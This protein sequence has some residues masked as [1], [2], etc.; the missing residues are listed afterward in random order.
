M[1]AAAHNDP[2]E[3]EIGFTPSVIHSSSNPV[4]APGPGP[5]PGSNHGNNNASTPVGGGGHRQPFH[6]A[7][8]ATSWAGAGTGATYTSPPKTS[9]AVFKPKA[10]PS[11]GSY[12][13]LS[14]SNDKRA[15]RETFTG[16][17]TTTATGVKSWEPPARKRPAPAAGPR[18]HNPSFANRRPVRP[19]EN[20]VKSPPPPNKPEWRGAQ[21]G[22]GGDR[23]GHVPKPWEKPRFE[24]AN[25]K[26]KPEW[27]RS[28]SVNDIPGPPSGGPGGSYYGPKKGHDEAPTNDYYGGASLNKDI[29]FNPP[30]PRFHPPPGT[31]RHALA[32]DDG[33]VKREDDSA[34]DQHQRQASPTKVRM[35]GSL[36]TGR[37]N[38]D[39]IS[40]PLASP[41]RYNSET[42]W[43]QQD[44]PFLK[45]RPSFA[46]PS[47]DYNEIEQG[48]IDSGVVEMEGD[49]S[50]GR[51][52]THGENA[53]SGVHSLVSAK[54][55][56]LSSDME[57]EPT[58]LAAPERKPIPVILTCASLQDKDAAKKAM[59]TIRI[60]SELMD[61]GVTHHS[62]SADC[63][64]LPNAGDVTKAL[65]ELQKQIKQGQQQSKLVK[66]KMK[67]AIRE[68]MAK[69]K[70]EEELREK[71][72]AN[73]VLKKADEEAKGNSMLLT[74]K[75]EENKVK[76]ERRIA[77]EQL[78]DEISKAQSSI[79]ELDEKIIENVKASIM[80]KYETIIGD[81]QKVSQ[82]ARAG[83]SAV[84]MAASELE[85]QLKDVEHDLDEGVSV[86]ALKRDFAAQ[87]EANSIKAIV[88]SEVSDELK[89]VLDTGV[90]EPD[91]LNNL[92]LS[93]MREN[94]QR[95]AQA[96]FESVTMVVPEAVNDMHESISPPGLV[97]ELP[98]E[99]EVSFKRYVAHW[100]KMTQFVTGPADALYSEPSLAPLYEKTWKQHKEIGPLVKEH[101]RSKK[102]KL[103]H[104]WTELAEEYAVREQLYEKDSKRDSAS[105]HSTAFGGSF[106]ICGQRR[107]GGAVDNTSNSVSA[108][109][110]GNSRSTNNPYRRPRRSAGLQV[111]GGDIVRSDYEQEQIILQLT[112]QENMERRIKLG[113]SDLPRQ[114]CRLEKVNIP[115]R[116]EMLCLRSIILTLFLSIQE[117]S[118]SF[119]DTMSSRR[120][121]DL[122]GDE[123]K[124]SLIN[125]WSDMEKCIFF[126]RFLQHPK[127]FRKIA[128]F[129][130][131]KNTHD[132][133]AFYYSSKQSVPYKAALKEHLMRKKKRGDNVSWEATIQAAISLGATVTAGI[134][135]EKPLLFHLPEN[136]QTYNTRMLH[137]ITLDLF[138]PS[139]SEITYEEPTEP[140][141]RKK[142]AALAT[143]FTL[144]QS[145]RKY[146]RGDSAMAGRRPS[147]SDAES[148]SSAKIS[149]SSSML[150]VPDVAT[151]T[152]QKQENSGRRGSNKW[153]ENEKTVFYDSLEKFGKKWT[154]ISEAIG[155]KTST[156]ARN[157]YYDQKRQNGGNKGSDKEKKEKESK[158]VKS[159]KVK[160]PSVHPSQDIPFTPEQ[161]SMH[162]AQ[163]NK[164]GG[165]PT[166]V[167]EE[168]N[169][170]GEGISGMDQGHT[171][172]LSSQGAWES[173]Q[174][175][176]A[177]EQHRR[178]QQQQQE[179][180]RMLEHQFA[181][182]QLLDQQRQIQHQQHQQHQHFLGM[183]NQQQN[184]MGG[185]PHWLA[186]QALQRQV[187]SGNPLRDFVDRGSMQSNAHQQFNMALAMRQLRQQ[188]Q[189]N[190]SLRN[191][192]DHDLSILARMA[193]ENA[194]RSNQQ[195]RNI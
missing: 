157:F 155:T 7:R 176:M 89:A 114:I 179:H 21:R 87:A 112:A 178:Q 102:R 78:L 46:P 45:R 20:N 8:R 137:P 135:S 80:T 1:N 144:E 60:M 159:E 14:E 131:N 50:F 110:A 5:G 63:V 125:P 84:S 186:V 99:D 35:D 11:L 151:T 128:S 104:R 34:S 119:K 41:R 184:D 88:P 40:G 195:N 163:M 83:V 96:H 108:A 27:R 44:K 17:A 118:A 97:Q 171:G 162:I 174:I 116:D 188:Q 24:P 117:L 26:W 30:G 39:N 143:T 111:A 156:Q 75:A 127:D 175:A 2:E 105:I 92:V 154:I 79:S 167:P 149:R 173:N 55:S 145:A 160:E 36:S 93:I 76:E 23:D 115:P 168:S 181:Q 177:I 49:G 54:R 182:Q 42:R 73:L 185:V 123:K 134:D 77:K 10:K 9:K 152:E 33:L 124:H 70:M 19:W 90:D 126:D 138:D 103:H 61:D 148:I 25:P 169:M 132:C 113:R 95:A 140:K 100:T 139:V 120:V 18:H 62:D 107:G 68:D 106:S 101:I 192:D 193:A 56:S 67:Q 66:F 4:H 6:A 43:K 69:K 82:E 133:I 65:E 91:D 37:G 85:A 94:K 153:S 81:A 53:L 164:P 150:S 109:D 48:Q 58:P 166:P 130:K 98:D 189:N 47:S 129:L 15:A 72:E 147:G 121:Y 170:V 31:E 122:L 141:L 22:G 142:K 59:K 3:G 172:M 74:A 51:N 191:G 16:T 52:G 136:D 64:P 194:S 158:K 12:A 28:S 165:L 183:L 57:V 146:L 86:E 29:K 32:N 38:F 187:D 13:S 161:I 71:E 180:Q 190:A